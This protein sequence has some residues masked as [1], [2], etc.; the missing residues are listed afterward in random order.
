MKIRLVFPVSFGGRRVFPGETID[1]PKAKA[2]EFIGNGWA[3]E[4]AEDKPKR[5]VKH[6]VERPNA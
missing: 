2:L 1:A 4:I 6:D 5:K 3:I